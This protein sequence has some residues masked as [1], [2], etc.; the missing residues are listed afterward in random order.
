VASSARD[1]AYTASINYL[2]PN[3]WRTSKVVGGTDAC[4][5]SAKT[6]KLPP[7]N[8]LAFIVPATTSAS[9]VDWSA[10]PVR[11]TVTP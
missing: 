3:V 11:L 10:P 4:E 2:Q 6:W 1:L 5:P 9:P 7:G 8:Y